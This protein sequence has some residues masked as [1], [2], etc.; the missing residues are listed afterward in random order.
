LIIVFGVF[1]LLTNLD[2]IPGNGWDYFWPL[3][4]VVIGLS[5]VLRKPWSPNEKVIDAN[6]GETFAAFSGVEKTIQSQ[7]YTG[8]RVTAVFGGTKLDLRTAGITDGATIEVFAA[9][10]GVE[11]LVPRDVKIVFSITPLFG[12]GNDKTQ[13]DATASKTLHIRGTALFGGVDVKN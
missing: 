5:I 8:G 12:G 1:L 9:F 13:P 2:W 4:I 11:L 3:V 6:G 10:G 7:A